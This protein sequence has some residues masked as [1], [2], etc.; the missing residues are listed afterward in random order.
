MQ[1]FDHNIGFLFK[2]TLVFLQKIVEIE[3]NCGHNIDP[4]SVKLHFDGK[5]I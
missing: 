3:E 4:C 5:F 2:K 1:K